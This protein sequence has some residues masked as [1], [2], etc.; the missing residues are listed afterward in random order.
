MTEMSVKELRTIC[1]QLQLYSTPELNDK[2]YLHYKGFKRIENLDEYTGLKVIY[3]EGNGLHRIEG[4]DK[5]TQLRCLYLQENMIEVMENMDTLID[6]D[7]LN[8]NQNMIKCVSGLKTLTK[9]NSLLLQGNKLKTLQDLQGLLERPSIGV[10]DLSKNEIDDPDIVESILLRMPNL[11]VLYLKENPLVEHIPN[12]RKKLISTLRNLTYLDDRPVFPEE[13]RTAE[14]WS[15][16]GKSAEQEERKKIEQ[17]SRDKER[18]NFEAFEKMVKEARM[19]RGETEEEKE[20]AKQHGDDDDAASTDEEGDD[21]S[22]ETDRAPPALEDVPAEEASSDALLQR[23][24]IKEAVHPALQPLDDVT[25][26]PASSSASSSSSAQPLLSLTNDKPSSSS[27]SSAHS[28]KPLIEMMDDETDEK[29]SNTSSAT[30]DTTQQ[31]N[32]ALINEMD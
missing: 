26:K 14:A 9:L 19:E 12:Y 8:L 2:I 24:N 32:I 30:T 5:L 31:P 28:R 27:S 29:A 13:R 21:E 10:L 4:L 7:T 20:E 6:L 16:G 1:R 3:L 11:K 15:R 18:R 23:L 22:K 25:A 17:E